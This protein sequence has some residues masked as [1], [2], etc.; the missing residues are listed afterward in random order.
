MLEVNSL[1]RQLKKILGWHQ[2]RITLLAQFIIA[3]I[4]VRSVNLSV[5]AQAFS[6][7]ALTS[8]YYKRL[9]RFLRGF[10]PDLDQCAQVIAQLFCPSGRWVLCM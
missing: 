2:A 8:S 4:K 9:Q 1:G 7:S 6:G 10:T 5:V 3:L